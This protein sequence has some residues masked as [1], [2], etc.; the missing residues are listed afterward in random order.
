VS[1]SEQH[2]TERLPDLS[3]DLV[4]VREIEAADAP[5]LFAL[6]ADP[7]V[8]AHMSPPPP[9]AA[10]FAGFVSWARQQ[11]ARGEGVSFGIV[12][13]GLSSA[14]GIIQVRALEPSFFTAEWGF[15]IGS[16]FWGTGAF[17]DAARLVAGFA[18]CTLKVHRLEARAVVANGRGNGA[19]RK[20]GARPE[21]ELHASFRRDDERAAQFLWSLTAEDLADPP[22]IG[23]FCAKEAAAA[24]RTAVESVRSRLETGRSAELP[25]KPADYPFF[26]SYKAK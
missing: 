19:L 8:A 5:G 11:R 2:W 22:A 1:G 12:P 25:G 20:L 23:R 17:V 6:L 16:P 14:V 18:F 26:V 15:A 24:I 7:A 3:G 21:G 9:S 13:H 10:A 4:A